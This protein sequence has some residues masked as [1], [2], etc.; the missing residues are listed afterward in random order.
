M[1]DLT[2]ADARKPT[3][4]ECLEALRYLLAA[5]E[6]IRK[7]ARA[8]VGDRWDNLIDN[9]ATVLADL[10]A[11][12]TLQDVRAWEDI[13]S[14]R[15][16]GVLNVLQ[17]ADTWDDETGEGFCVDSHTDKI[18]DQHL[19]AEILD[20]PDVSTPEELLAFV[21]GKELTVV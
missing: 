1:P 14:L 12:K 3:E 19:T 20:N 6:S 17:L 9:A 11:P 13:H 16:A 4:S 5:P 18:I 10:R 7:H 15:E 21:V 8:L 2:K